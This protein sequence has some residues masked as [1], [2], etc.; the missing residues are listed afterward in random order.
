MIWNGCS[1]HYFSFNKKVLQ[2]NVLF[3][4]VGFCVIWEK[5]IA[6]KG[7]DIDNIDET[8][9]QNF[10][11]VLLTPD[12]DVFFPTNW[13]QWIY[14]KFIDARAT[15]KLPTIIV[16]HI[17]LDAVFFIYY[18][19]RFLANIMFCPAFLVCV[20]HRFITVIKKV[21]LYAI[22]VKQDFC[23]FLIR[24][25]PVWKKQSHSLFSIVTIIF[26]GSYIQYCVCHRCEITLSLIGS[27]LAFFSCCFFRFTHQIKCD[28]YIS[29]WLINDYDVVV[30][31]AEMWQIFLSSSFFSLS[32]CRQMTLLWR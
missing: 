14:D 5:A 22:M 9:I 21:D 30:K 25:F 3:F 17:V 11:Y 8:G 1:L 32:V 26:N 15:Q 2:L 20:R 6:L 4:R 23:Q 18:L 10:I 12:M 31:S 7:T 29:R 27:G 16:H 28:D 13:E 24:I 19:K